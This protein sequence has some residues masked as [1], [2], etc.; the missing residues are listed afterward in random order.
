MTWR[1]SMTTFRA[2]RRTITLAVGVLLAVAPMPLLGQQVHMNFRIEID[3]PDPL[4]TTPVTAT[5]AAEFFDSCFVVCD[6][7]GQWVGPQEF[8]IDWY[9]EDRHDQVGMLSRHLDAV[10]RF[11]PGSPGTK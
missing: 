7:N 5:V 2:L 9:I 11:G 6:V 10:V 3:P 4:D 1:A 8:H